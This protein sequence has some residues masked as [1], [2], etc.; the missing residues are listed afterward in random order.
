MNRN[1]LYQ[2]ITDHIVAQLEKGVAP[3]QQPWAT[4]G[5]GLPMNVVSRKPYRGIN[6]LLLWGAAEEHGYESSLW[7]TY[8][9]WD[10][11]GGHVNRGERST[12]IIYWNVTNQTVVDRQ[13]GVEKEESGSSARNTRFSTST[14]AAGRP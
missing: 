2:R 10:M 12:K 7:A 14:S 3:W 4:I 1:D 8:R 11:L 13:T 6:T 5:G 9:Q